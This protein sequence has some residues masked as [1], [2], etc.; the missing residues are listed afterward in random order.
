MNFIG[1]L[2][3]NTAHTWPYAELGAHLLGLTWA[4]GASSDCDCS[5]RAAARARARACVHA[6]RL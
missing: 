4:A 3:W 6:I 2:V 1:P 5:P